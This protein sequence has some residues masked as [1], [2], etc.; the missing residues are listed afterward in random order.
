MTFRLFSLPPCLRQSIFAR[1]GFTP[2]PHNTARWARHRHLSSQFF[3]RTS[4]PPP[5]IGRRLLWLIPIAGGFALYAAPQPRSFWPTL[6]D[7]PTLIPCPPPAPPPP[8]QSQIA[9]TILSPAESDRTLLR[10]IIS[11]LNCSIWEPIL[12]ARRF[13]FLCI[14]FVPVILTAPMLVVGR[15]DTRLLGDR[16]G[17]VWW[18]GFL[19]SQM[20]R[21]GPTFIKVRQLF[22]AHICVLLLTS[23]CNMYSSHNGQHPGQ[24]CSPLYFVKNSAPCILEERR[25]RSRIQSASS[26]AFSNARLRKCLRSLMRRLSVPA[27]LPK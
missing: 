9:H 4:A 19:T 20:Q 6:F 11:F 12:T 17:A 10:R 22:Y 5:Q 15:P 14:L 3:T 26:N 27:Q 1:T 25:I 13:I 18:Y 21:A 7:S 16:W 23:G 8:D 24:I 2:A